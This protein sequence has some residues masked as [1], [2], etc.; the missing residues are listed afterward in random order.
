[1]NH[2]QL[3]FTIQ[4]VSTVRELVRGQEQEFIEEMLPLVLN[5]SVRLD[6]SRI[7]RIDAAGLAALISVSCDAGRAGHAF[8]VVNPSHQVARI[9]AVV[10]LD[11]A[12]MS[13]D[14]VQAQNPAPRL[15]LVAA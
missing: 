4:F 12:L 7:E 13:N 14:P 10:G 6:L 1:M 2:P 3:D 9:L 15:D 5:Q 8:T 11:H